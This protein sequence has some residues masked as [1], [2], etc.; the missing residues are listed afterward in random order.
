[1][2]VPRT[3]DWPLQPPACGPC[4]GGMQ[5]PDEDITGLLSAGATLRY[6]KALVGGGSG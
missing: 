3:V 4:Q 6:L 2:H 1:M 5:A